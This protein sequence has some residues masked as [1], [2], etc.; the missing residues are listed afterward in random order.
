[1]QLT[2]RPY[3]KDELRPLLP[4]G[5]YPFRVESATAKTSSAGNPMIELVIKARNEGGTT[6]TIYD[7]LLMPDTNSDDEPKIKS[8]TWKIRNFC[9]SVGLE[10]E[11]MSG[12]LSP[13][14]CNGR[15]GNAK[16]YV[17][18]DPNG[19]YADKNRVAH[20]IESDDMIN[21]NKN[22]VS[23]PLTRNEVKNKAAI[24]SPSGSMVEDDRN[25][26]PF[27]DDIPF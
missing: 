4:P 15:S 10:D 25:P 21:L 23:K 18:Q 19:K 17:E 3:S 1:M 24:N 20:Y 16:L 14:S 9:Y 8:K 13:I 26:P 6:V 22:N 11:Y 5:I 27:D 7:Y 2:Y 12:T